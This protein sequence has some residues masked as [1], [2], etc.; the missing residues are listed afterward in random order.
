LIF[1]LE[2]HHRSFPGKLGRQRSAGHSSPE[3]DDIG[4]Q[5]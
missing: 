3:D 2:Q 5:A 1:D 4:L